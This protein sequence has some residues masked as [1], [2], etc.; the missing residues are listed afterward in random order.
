MPGL[1]VSAQIYILSVGVS[2]LALLLTTWLTEPVLFTQQT[3]ITAVLMLAI[4]LASEHYVIT[5]PRGG[6]LAA[7]T[8]PQIASIF[9]LPPSLVL[10]ITATSTV[11][12]D[13]TS[14]KEW[15][16]ALFNTGQMMLAVGLPAHLINSFGSARDVLHVGSAAH[17]MPLAIGAVVLYYALNTVLTNT[18][19]AL[20]RRTSI[21]GVWLANNST[22]MLLEFGMGIIGVL[23]AYIWL[24]DPLWSLLAVCPA[25]MACRAFGHIRRLEDEN[26]QGILAIAETIDARDPYT[27][28]HSKRV[29]EYAEKIATALQLGSRYV[30]IL[31]SAARLHDLGKIGIGNDILHKPSRLSEEDWAKM[32]RHPEIGAEI[33]SRY[34]LYRDGLDCVRHH[35]ERYDGTGYPDGLRGEEIPLGAR[36]MAVADAYEAMTSD[37]PYRHAL[38]REVAIEELKR[39]MGTQFDPLVVAVFLKILDQE[40]CD[41]RDNLGGYR[42]QPSRSRSSIPETGAALVDEAASRIA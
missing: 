29:A 15:Y 26:E 37:R 35:H 5:L 24:L 13:I 32:R 12:E 23:W 8:I 4:T 3:L 21:I 1:R 16:K 22:S 11:I 28:Q 33:L 30:E 14:R 19:I 27:F 41:T 10:L 20:D 17:G 31:A 7:S 40:V 34:K 36:I 18:I 25:I 9:I 6:E 39:G 2:G 42:M 38:P